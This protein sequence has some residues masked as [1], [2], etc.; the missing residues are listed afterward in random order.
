MQRTFLL[1]YILGVAWFS[2]C[3]AEG[4]PPRPIQLP[5]IL[6]WKRIQTPAVSSDGQWFAY[7]LAPN[8]G[9]AE[10][11][12]RNLQD[13]KELRFTMGEVPRPEIRPGAPPPPPVRDLAISEDSKWAA[14]LV[15]PS[16]RETRTLTKQKKPIQTK[17]M[18]IELATGQKT[19][20]EKIRRFAFSGEKST[21]IALHRYSPTSTPATPA[22]PPPPAN[23][24]PAGSD[25]LLHE[26]S[27]G[28]ELNIGN[29]SEFAFDTKGNWLA[30]VV[31][32]QEKAGNGVAVRNMTSGVVIPLDSARASY[33]G[34]NWTENGDGLATL[35]GVED[36]AWEDKLY[37]LVAF[38]NFSAAASPEK[39]VYDP[40]QD[41]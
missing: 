31:D 11:V 10:V 23:D 18:L 32:A 37:A 4:T 6:A 15:Y 19:E 30:W 28:S 14:F 7:K 13:D 27:T 9:N 17:L 20:F 8:E 1:A 38:K 5:D 22:A 26:L 41:K 39:I 24:R 21:A 33:K 2:P 36:K 25:L 16:A 40:A 12:L 29:V 34:L 3:R 35:R